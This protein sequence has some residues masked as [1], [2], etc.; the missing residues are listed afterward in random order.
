MRSEEIYDNL[1]LT[2][3]RIVQVSIPAEVAFNLERFQQVQKDILGKLGCM[4]C[5]SGWDIRFDIQRRFV[6]GA[7]LEVREDMPRG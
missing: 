5:C 7:N 1:R 6:V 4:A 2:N 3:N